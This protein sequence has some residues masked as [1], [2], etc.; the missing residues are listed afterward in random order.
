MTDNKD[1]KR[2]LVTGSKG[3]LGQSLMKRKED[4]PGME[5]YF[6]D[7]DELNIT[8]KQAVLSL[9][10]SMRPDFCI[11]TAAYTAVD[12]AETEK[13]LSQQVN[14]LG[15]ENL[16]LACTETGSTLI[17]ISTDYVY[18]CCDDAIL[19][20]DFSTTP[21]S[22]YGI[23]KLAGEKEIINILD[24]YV[25]IRTSW[26][27]SEFGHNFVKTMIKLGSE[28][29]EIRVVND[30]TGSPT[31][32]TDLAEALLKIV[33]SGDMH[34]G[35][36]NYSNEGFT[37][38]YEFAKHIFAITGQ[39]CRVLPVPGS[40]YPTAASRPKNSRLSKEKIR[41]TYK[42]DIPDWKISLEKCISLFSN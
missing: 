33:N 29:G 35:I 37:S 39:K 11:N 30:Q 10:R 22:W 31:Y 23:S 41:N 2:V 40:E 13:D 32:A 26:L 19:T 34:Y 24:K 9:F 4:F 1:K 16:A 27:Y 17:H 20:E 14:Q 21:K 15:P 36:Y 12:K 6:T 25:I 38:W 8:D 42:L 5:I 3:Q 7:I 18:D 28:K